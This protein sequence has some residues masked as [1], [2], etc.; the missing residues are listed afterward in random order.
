MAKYNHPR[1]QSDCALGIDQKDRFVTSLAQRATQA[2]QGKGTKGT[3]CFVLTPFRR[4]YVA[5]TLATI[6]GLLTACIRAADPI[7]CMLPA[8]AY[9]V[10]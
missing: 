7:T 8:R 2:E 6:G 1:V 4:M 10:P 3:R 5:A 9:V